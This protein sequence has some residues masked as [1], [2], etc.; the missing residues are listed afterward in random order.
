MALVIATEVYAQRGARTDD[1]KQ[2]ES[3]ETSGIKGR[4]DNNAVFV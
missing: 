1:A 2:H 3:I 4:M